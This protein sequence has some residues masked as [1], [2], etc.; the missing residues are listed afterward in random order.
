MVCLS[1]WL[2][3][4]KMINF[5]NDY[6]ISHG[7]RCD[8]KLALKHLGLWQHELLVVTSINVLHGSL[9]SPP[10]LQ[11][12]REAAQDYFKTI[13]PNQCQLLGMH[14]RQIISQQNLDINP[15]SPTA[16]EVLTILG[17]LSCF[18]MV[19]LQGHFITI[20]VTLFVWSEAVYVVAV[21][22]L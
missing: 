12:F 14:L 10:R 7:S 9:L 15:S 21:A 3:Y 17:A 6:D 22:S 4:K 1:G 20:T 13:D 19:K 2:L 16:C 8:L 11:Q 5:K 18:R